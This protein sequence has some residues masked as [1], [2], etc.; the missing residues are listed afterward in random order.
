VEMAARIETGKRVRYKGG[1]D[2]NW[3]AIVGDYW[4]TFKKLSCNKAS[5]HFHLSRQRNIAEHDHVL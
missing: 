4:Y 5:L 3:N 2:G 1:N